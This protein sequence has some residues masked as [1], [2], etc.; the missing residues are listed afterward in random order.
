MFRSRMFRSRW[1]GPACLALALTGAAR[2]QGTSAAGAPVAHVTAPAPV[3][4][5][6][7]APPA[8]G[9]AAP[10]HPVAQAHAGPPGHPAPLKLPPPPG[11]WPSAF[12]T[13]PDEAVVEK[14][15]EKKDDKALV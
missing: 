5:R 1:L 15:D 12:V 10:P 14:K 6:A 7:E 9:P 4:A 11:G 3:A 2:G 13:G 8:A